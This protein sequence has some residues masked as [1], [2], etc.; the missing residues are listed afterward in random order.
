MNMVKKT[1]SG[2]IT[3]GVIACAA[4]PISNAGA[5]N[6]TQLYKNAVE[7]ASAQS[8]AAGAFYAN[9]A[10]GALYD[11]DENGVDELILLYTVKTEQIP[12]L[13]SR[14]YTLSGGQIVTLLD[15]EPLYPLA[16]GPNGAVGVAQRDGQNLLYVQ[17][18][19]GE[20]GIDAHRGGEWTFYQMVDNKMSE[21]ESVSY[22][23]VMSDLSDLDNCTGSAVWDGSAISWEEYISR[24]SDITPEVKLTEDGAGSTLDALLDQI[25]NMTMIE[26]PSP[27][28]I[29]EVDAARES[30]LIPSDLDSNYQT[31]IT[32][33]EFCHLMSQHLATRTGKSVD[34][35]LSDAGIEPSEPYSDTRDEDILAMSALGIVNGVG[36]NR[37]DPDASITREEAAV[38]LARVTTKFDGLKTNSEPMAF[39]DQAQISLWAKEA[40]DV[41]SSCA[42]NGNCI[43]NGTG[44]SIFSPNDTYTREQSIMTS[45]RLYRFIGDADFTNS[46][47]EIGSLL[48][49]CYVG[50]YK[51][52]YG[53]YRDA[54]GSTGSIILNPDGTADY[55]LDI[56]PTTEFESA[57]SIRQYGIAWEVDVVEDFGTW[58][59]VIRFELEDVSES[60]YDGRQIYTVLDDDQFGMNDVFAFQLVG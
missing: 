13:V 26:A 21:V 38:M 17:S 18:E 8:S 25:D 41:V 51:L 5:V 4:N 40:V 24:T 7:E 14:V 33:E 30:G 6:G 1:I 42:Y 22:E 32:R 10:R 49:Y 35:L 52:H 39:T 45:L 2:L 44:E 59:P 36:N 28:A 54:N 11:I 23:Y 27:W 56:A 46:E 60:P 55:C 31:N 58:V 50:G 29:E 16:G 34:E 12:Y 37:F 57:I 48:P 9:A 15:K 53:E 3:L 20:T 47:R 19:S 43:M